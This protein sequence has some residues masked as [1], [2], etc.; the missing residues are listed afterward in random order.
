MKKI[1]LPV[2]FSEQTE[3][4]CNYALQMAKKFNAEIRLF[5]SYFDQ[6]IISDGS[7]PTGVDTDT[8]LNEQLL[9]DIEKRSKNDILELQS[10]M[11]DEVKKEGLRNVKVVYTIVGGEPESEIIEISQSYK[12]DIIIMGT[13]G[14]TALGVLLGSVSKKIMNNAHVPVL[15]IPQ[16]YQFKELVEVMYMTD[17]KSDDKHNSKQTVYTAGRF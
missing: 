9:R 6:V 12:P 10:K 16:G 4:A 2:D 5:H 3:N 13:R 14:K 7:F 8:M 11:L 17:F 1:L 15:A